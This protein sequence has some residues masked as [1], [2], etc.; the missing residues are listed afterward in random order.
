MSASVWAT[1]I[2]KTTCID[3]SGRRRGALRTCG[4]PYVT[5]PV[6]PC[7]TLSW[8][9]RECSSLGRMCFVCNWYRSVFAQTWLSQNVNMPLE[10]HIVSARYLLFCCSHRF[11]SNK[12][13]E[14]SYSAFC[15]SSW[16][17]PEMVNIFRKN[18]PAMSWA[19]TWRCVS[20]VLERPLSQ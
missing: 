15:L 17:K 19:A 8:H 5:T 9:F 1:T 20:I 14:G 16:N 6:R 7:R 2:G 10:I 18:R 12:T 4:R 3:S 13:V 11:T